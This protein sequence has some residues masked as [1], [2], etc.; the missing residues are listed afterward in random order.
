MYLPVARSFRKIRIAWERSWLR[1]A[2]P[3]EMIKFLRTVWRLF[4][5][6]W[7]WSSSFVAKW[8][9]TR[10][11]FMKALRQVIVS[12]RFSPLLR[13]VRSLSEAYIKIRWR[14]SPKKFAREYMIRRSIDMVTLQFHLIYVLMQLGTHNKWVTL[15]RECITIFW[16]P[17]ENSL[18]CRNLATR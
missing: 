1:S 7:W 6:L 18:F 2:L 5:Q 17:V 3:C 15:S 8:L 16:V 12:Q 14:K 10:P 13:N 4:E 9:W 11:H